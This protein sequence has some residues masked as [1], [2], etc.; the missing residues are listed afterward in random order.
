MS[1]SFSASVLVALAALATV[2]ADA[3]PPRYGFGRAPT[4][5]EIAGWDIDVRPDGRGLPPGRGTVAQGQVLYDAKCASC[6]G[7]FGES[8]DYMAIAGGVGTLA[9]DQPIRTTGSKL[10]HATTLFDY[11]RRAM[12]FNAPQTLTD[13][14]TYALTAYVL[15]LS[16]IL[17]ADAVLDPV[18][19][20]AVRMPNRDGFTTSH[21]LMARGGR[22]DTANVACMRDCAPEVRVASRIPE[23]ARGDHGDLASQTR[24]L[25]AEVK[26]AKAPSSRSP[27][28]LAKQSACMACHAVSAKLVGPSFRDVA[29]K[30]AG[31]S[32]APGKLASRIR[33]GSVGTWG[34]VPMPAQPQLAE[35]DALALA[36]WVLGGAAP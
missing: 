17:P 4:Q 36:R 9:S 11:I 33:A 27:A 13:D 28:E 16:D 1:S 19:I 3:A 34:V 18:S 2:A 10:N 30:Y 31:D 5:Q 32:A 23:H 35:S 26:V 20:L 6:H 8:T 12:P 21:G 29:A 24:A 15:H 22:P 7:T 14:E 25:A